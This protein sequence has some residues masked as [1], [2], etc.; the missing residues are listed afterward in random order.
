MSEGQRWTTN[1]ALVREGSHAED[2]TGNQQRD[3]VTLN[4]LSTIQ[5]PTNSS[6]DST[7]IKNKLPDGVL[8]IL[9]EKF[10][11]LT[12]GP[13]QLAPLTELVTI[14]GTIP[15]LHSLIPDLSQILMKMQITELEESQEG[16]IMISWP[17]F[18]SYFGLKGQLPNQIPNYRESNSLNEQQQVAKR[19]Q[20]NQFESEI[21]QIESAIIK[22]FKEL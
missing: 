20:L 8:S 13:Y 1:S 5:R 14:L 7:A 16:K 11:P 6:T 10:I 18:V 4:L 15:I 3:S 9:T 19:Q 12:Q 17:K 22:V 21:D 2:Q